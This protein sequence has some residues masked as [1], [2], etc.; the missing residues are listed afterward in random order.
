MELWQLCGKVTVLALE[1]V[2]IFYA[3]I[4]KQNGSTTVNGSQPNTAQAA[5]ALHQA[6]AKLHSENVSFVH[7][8]PFI[9]LGR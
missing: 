5:Q 9:Y 1:T 4:F 7:W 6:V 8:V 3:N 2:D